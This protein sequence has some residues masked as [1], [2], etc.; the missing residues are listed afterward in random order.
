MNSLDYVSGL[1]V[2]LRHDQHC[3]ALHIYV[4]IAGGWWVKPYY[5]VTSPIAPNGLFSIDY[6]TGGY[7]TDATKFNA[8]AVTSDFVPENH[9][10]PSLSD[11]RVKADVQVDR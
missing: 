8:A 6:T 3:V 11:S 2:N 5:G 4:P 9:T 1:A 7:D 10:L